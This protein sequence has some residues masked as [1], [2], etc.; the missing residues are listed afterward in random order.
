MH[1]IAVDR[2]GRPQEELGRPGGRPTEVTQLSVGNGRLVH[3]VGR[4][5]GRLTVGSAVFGKGYFGPYKRTVWISNVWNL[6]ERS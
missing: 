4:P 2:S 6:L 5:A 1:S 3:G